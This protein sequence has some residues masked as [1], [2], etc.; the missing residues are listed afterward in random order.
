MESRYDYMWE[1]NTRDEEGDGD[2]WP[3]PLSIDYDPP[4]EKI[5]T[6]PNGYELTYSDMKKLWLAY[7][8]ATGYTERDDILYQVN[9]IPNIGMLEPGDVI[10]MFNT[11]LVSQYSFAN[12]KDN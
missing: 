11:Y 6:L 5:K 3:D 12:L 10:Y 4:L 9:D 1:S 2:F 7:Y 8:K